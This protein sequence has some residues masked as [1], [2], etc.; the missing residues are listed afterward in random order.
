MT[1]KV[2][3]KQKGKDGTLPDFDMALVGRNARFE[4]IITRLP[5][6][7]FFKQPHHGDYVNVTRNGVYFCRAVVTNPR[8][9][10]VYDGKSAYYSANLRMVND[11]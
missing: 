1:T 5:L 3:T 10:L 11:E 6:D 4:V 9:G 2:S 7:A 8:M